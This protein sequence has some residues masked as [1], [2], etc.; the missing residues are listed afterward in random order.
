ML[1]TISMPRALQVEFAVVW[2]RHPELWKQVRAAALA[3]SRGLPTAGC[4]GPAVYQLTSLPQAC[5]LIP[6]K[7][8]PQP[9]PPQSQCPE[10]KAVQVMGAGVDSQLTDPDLPP[11]IPLLR[12][13]DPLM[14]ERMAT[15]IMWGWVQLVLGL[16]A[17]CLFG[18]SPLLNTAP[19][20]QLL[21]LVVYSL[22]PT[23]RSAGSS[24]RRYALNLTRSVSA[25]LWSSTGLACLVSV[26]ATMGGRSA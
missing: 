21:P 20:L 3:C 22:L 24:M 5:N 10:L 13:I 12:I 19:A 25:Q 8:C 1:N 7:P 14:S 9:A 2:G 16:A 11:E 23:L 26:L 15:W 17:L 4:A 18:S 6:V